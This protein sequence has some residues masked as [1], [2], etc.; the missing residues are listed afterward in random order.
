MTKTHNGTGSITP[1]DKLFSLSGKVAIVTGAA[2]QLG[3]EYVQTLLAANA[4]VAAFDIR[5]DNPKSKLGE[6]DSDNLLLVEADITK[7]KSLEEGLE[8]V[9]S[10]FAPPT[11]LV[12]NAAVDAPPNASE[13]ETG[14]FETY[15]ESS[16]RAIMDVNLTGMFLS[17]QVIG[18]R[19]QRG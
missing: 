7:R 5:L 19:L 1:V 12:N 15:P 16:W 14:P 3:G 6:I 10:R 4:S 2:G 13:Q 18:E 11:I 9:E 8:E 17:C